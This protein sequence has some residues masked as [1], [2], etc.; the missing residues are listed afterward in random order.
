M[1]LLDKISGWLGG[2][3]SA[4]G[5]LFI[6][7]GGGVI[8]PRPNYRPGPRDMLNL[9]HKL[10][11]FSEREKIRVVCL[12]EGDPLHKAADGDELQ[13]VTVHYATSA[14][15]RSA[16]LVELVKKYGGRSTR[17]IAVVP[18]PA[19]EQ[20]VREAGA[21]PLR[22]STFRKALDAGDEGG[23]EGRSG[24]GRG[25]GGGGDDRNRQRRRGGRGGDYRGPRGEGR[26]ENRGEN[27]GER[28]DREDRRPANPAPGESAPES[29]PSEQKPASS[30]ST[31]EPG[32]SV[33]NLVDLV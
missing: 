5:A 17:V 3:D 25:G 20:A 24:E 16:R 31:Q 26:G 12:F 8:H 27:R 11:R 6:V 33:R 23:G 29:A 19:S 21:Q 28:G 14:S 9:L 22:C 15:D 30:G 32:G 4:A 7:D 10:G 1:G 2:G 18:D 13:G